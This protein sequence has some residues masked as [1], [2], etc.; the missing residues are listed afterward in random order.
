[1]RYVDVLSRKRDDHTPLQKSSDRCWRWGTKSMRATWHQENSSFFSGKTGQ[2]HIWTQRWWQQAQICTH[3]RQTEIQAR[4]ISRQKIPP[5]LKN[6]WQL[7]AARRWKI[8]FLK[9]SDIGYINHTPRKPPYLRVVRKLKLDS[10]F[11]FVSK[12]EEHGVGRIER[13]RRSLEELEEG[14]KCD[15]IHYLKSLKIK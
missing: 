14:K 12:E 8:T 1:M 10:M 7:T 13:C 9:R 4:I 5:Q 6:F 2:I 3:S 11:S 15:W